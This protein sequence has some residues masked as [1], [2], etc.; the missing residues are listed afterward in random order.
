M[1]SKVYQQTSQTPDSRNPIP[2]DVGRVLD[3]LFWE[4]GRIND[5]IDRLERESRLR[6][7]PVVCRKRS[8]S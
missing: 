6:Q 5:R 4:L 1:P 7:G 3:R 2:I 8:Q